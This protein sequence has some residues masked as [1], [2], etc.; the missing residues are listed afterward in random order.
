M[1]PLSVEIITYLFNKRIVKPIRPIFMGKPACGKL[2]S[3]FDRDAKL[4]LD[5][6]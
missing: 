5:G 3:P 1:A 2:I 6:F 4:A